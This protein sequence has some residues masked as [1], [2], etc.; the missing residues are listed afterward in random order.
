MNIY[1]ESNF[2][3]ELALMQEQHESCRKILLLC[4]RKKANLILP[5]YSIAEPYETLIRRERNRK[6]LAQNIANEL[7]Q[8]SRTE[9]YKTESDNYQTVASFLVKSGEEEN[10]RLLQTHKQ[11]LEM[12]QIIPLEKDVFA[13]A[14]QLKIQFDFSPQD[15]MVYAS[16]LQHLNIH[17]FEKSCFLNKNSKDFDDPDIEESLMKNN[18]KLLFSFEKGFDYINS[19]T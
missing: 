11:L 7:Q 2:V 9:L 16:V 8:L 6:L 19:Q 1:V 18:C 15:A 4:E 13:S 17:K 3:L 10:E 12:A 14:L 5:A